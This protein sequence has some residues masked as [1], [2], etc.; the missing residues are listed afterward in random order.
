[1]VKALVA[2][3]KYLTSW[4]IKPFVSRCCVGNLTRMLQTSSFNQT[5]VLVASNNISL[6]RMEG[7]IY[8]ITSTHYFIKSTIISR[9]VEDT[10][11]NTLVHTLV[12][13]KYSLACWVSRKLIPKSK[14]IP[15]YI[16]PRIASSRL[17]YSSSIQ[18]PKNVSGSATWLPICIAKLSRNRHYVN[19]TAWL[20]WLLNHL[21][22][23]IWFTV[24]RQT[25]HDSNA[26]Y[27]FSDHT[28]VGCFFALSL[29]LPPQIL[30]KS[31]LSQR[32]VNKT[33]WNN[34]RQTRI[35]YIFRRWVII[36]A[37][38]KQISLYLLLHFRSRIIVLT[39]ADNKQVRCKKSS[40]EITRACKITQ[41]TMMR[42]PVG[43]KTREYHH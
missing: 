40:A 10:P 36:K 3:A 29:S 6:S 26:V 11:G 15:C 17:A 19:W 37:L 5:H 25:K 20:E 8:I 28:N 39:C 35:C 34:P 23:Q 1:M 4:F 42:G 33:S 41:I 13:D 27:Y 2:L 31:T 7:R 32:T 12:H 14:T 24:I 16:I 30:P 18:Y 22:W 9:C 38:L 21:Q 43:V